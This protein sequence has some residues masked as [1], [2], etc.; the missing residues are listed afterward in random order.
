MEDLVKSFF[1]ILCYL[2]ILACLMAIAYM[3]NRWEEELTNGDDAQD[4]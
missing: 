3:C 1:E 4:N 2:K